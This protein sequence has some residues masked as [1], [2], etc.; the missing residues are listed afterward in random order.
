MEN[1]KQKLRSISC[2]VFDVDGVLT[3]G[4]LILL[5]GGEQVRTMNIRD[6]FAMQ[7]AVKKG[8]H[9][10][11]ISGGKS[12]A[13][14]TRLNGLG[15]TDVFLG[16]DE[17]IN[18]L[19]DMMSK[20]NLKAENI[21]YMGDDIPDLATMKMCGIAACP[22]DAVPEIKDICIYV[23]DKNGGNGCVRDIIEQTMRLHGQWENGN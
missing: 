17:K 23:S 20:Y 5:P 8:F 9:I 16:V 13:V 10:V 7:L 15:V 22:A 18:K 4:S 21:L 1:F 6:G 14:K 19:N 2:F 12:E 11:V 3:D